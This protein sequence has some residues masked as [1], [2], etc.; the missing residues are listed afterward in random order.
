M[1]TT[2]PA[3]SLPHRARPLAAAWPLL[4][5]A[6]GVNLAVLAVATLLDAGLAVDNAGTV[7]SVGVVEVTAASI[8]PLGLAIVA[9]WLLAPRI[10][11]VRRAWT[12]V[13]SVLTLL[14]LGA[15]TGAVD[16]TTAVA[17]GTMHLVVGG[18]AAFGVPARLGE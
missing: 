2:T 4:A 16:L 1:S 11:H 3:T 9:H 6:V 5:V 12:P 15:V 17:L 10:A 7:L 8:L 18:L 13:V 14:S